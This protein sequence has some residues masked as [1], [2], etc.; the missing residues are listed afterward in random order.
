VSGLGSTGWVP[1]TVDE[2]RQ[3]A[4]ETIRTALGD[5]VDVSAE[6]VFGPLIAALATKLGELWELVGSVYNARVPAGASGAALE[7]LCELSPGIERRAA[8]K[9]TVTLSVTLN[10]GVTL[11]TGSRASVSG[12]P[13]NAWVTTEDVTNSTGSPATVSVAAEALDAGRT[14]ANAGTITVIATPVTG[15]TAVTNAADATPGLEI[16]TDAELR[17]RREQRLQRAGS[18]PLESIEAELSEVDG[19]TQA[20]AWENATDY[21]DAFGRPPHSVEVMVLG[22]DSEDIARAIW[23]AKAAGIQTYGT[24]SVVTFTDDRG[25]TRSVYFSRPTSLSAYATLL[26]ITD[27][28]TYAGDA[29]VE[30]AFLAA[31]EGLRAGEVARNA[32]A[33]AALLEVTGVRD[34]VVWMGSTSTPT[35]QTRDN[36]A[37]TERQ[38]IVFDSARVEVTSS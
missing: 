20:I 35:S 13:S 23:A 3:E 2:L 32:I 11:P 38:R 17:L 15:W 6:S 27:P 5:D 9:G 4:E 37:P 1:K 16:E 30:T 18:S 29:A 22:G 33:V 34:A 25:V 14:P 28:A 7:A 36:L 8:T 26:I 31:M 21:T 19:V 10:A 12:E 24:E